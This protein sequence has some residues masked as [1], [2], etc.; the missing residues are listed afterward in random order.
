MFPHQ[1]PTSI[2][3]PTCVPHAPL[4]TSS[5]DNPNMGR[6]IMKLFITQFSPVSCYFHPLRTKYVPQYP[7]LTRPDNYV[8]ILYRSTIEV[9]YSNNQQHQLVNF[10][11]PVTIGMLPSAAPATTLPTIRTFCIPN[12]QPFWTFI[13]SVPSQEQQNHYSFTN[14][15]TKT[16]VN[17]QNRPPTIYTTT[18]STTSPS[19]PSPAPSRSVKMNLRY[20]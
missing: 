13:S 14:S 5:S 6:Q 16:K 3:S 19:A 9:V 17:N 18:Q 20:G 10:K 15:P 7:T 4:I 1:N 12:R 2:P 11:L 8:L